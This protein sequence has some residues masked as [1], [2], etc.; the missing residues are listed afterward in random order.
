[1]RST[2]DER[3]LAALLT[4]S[5]SGVLCPALG[6]KAGCSAAR[7]NS[8]SKPLVSDLG[9]YLGGGVTLIHLHTYREK[10]EYGYWVS[11]SIRLRAVASLLPLAE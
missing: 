7:G 8:R 1:M 6:H 10:S 9:D 11:K 5:V 2:I 3:E 4:R